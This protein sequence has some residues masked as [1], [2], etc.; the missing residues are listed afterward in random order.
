[1]EHPEMSIFRVN[2][3]I[4]C[5][6]T[7]SYLLQYTV[8]VDLTNVSSVVPRT[9]LH[10]VNPSFTQVYRKSALNLITRFWTEKI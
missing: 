3:F 8:D 2:A 4:Q 5:Q 10:T 1:M 7:L 6:L 9:Y